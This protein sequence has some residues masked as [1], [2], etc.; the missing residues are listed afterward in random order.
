M[1]ST[2]TILFFKA[3]LTYEQ[4]GIFSEELP[5]IMI[6]VP[7]VLRELLERTN[8]ALIWSFPQVF[9]LQ[10][11]L[12]GLHRLDRISRSIWCTVCTFFTWGKL[13]G[14]I[15]KTGICS[16]R[17]QKEQDSSPIYVWNRNC[18]NLFYNQNQMFFIKV[19]KCPIVLV[20]TWHRYSYKA[21]IYTGC[22]LRF[23]TRMVLV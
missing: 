13:S 19:K 17:K 21:C 10:A 12:P 11:F 15:F 18:S 2:F 14:L 3:V 1:Q 23:Y 8:L 5:I 16:L 9:C 4:L 7:L 6:N 20:E 22:Y